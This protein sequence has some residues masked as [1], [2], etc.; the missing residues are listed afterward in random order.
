MAARPQLR[1][2]EPHM[3]YYD[4][5]TN[6]ALSIRG[7]QRYKCNDYHLGECS[8]WNKTAQFILFENTEEG[9]LVSAFKN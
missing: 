2:V 7:F 4:E 5:V 6:D 9:R 3:H 1:I 8:T